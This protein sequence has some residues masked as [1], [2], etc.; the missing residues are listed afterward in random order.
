MGFVLQEDDSVT[1]CIYDPDS[2]D[3]TIQQ[4]WNVL[5]ENEVLEDVSGI[6]VFMF[7]TNTLGSAWPDS[8]CYSVS[9]S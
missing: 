3:F 5:Y 6:N 9:L 1:D 4:S 7:C 2:G 8:V